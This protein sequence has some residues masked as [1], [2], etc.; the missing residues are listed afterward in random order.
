MEEDGESAPVRFRFKPRRPSKRSNVAMDRTDNSNV[1]ATRSKQRLA[2][3]LAVRPVFTIVS[4][5]GL[6]LLLVILAA[7][8]TIAAWSA[9]AAGPALDTILSGHTPSDGDLNA[10]VLGLE[11]AVLWSSSGGR[12]TDLALLRAVQAERLPVDSPHR[13]AM[14]MQ[15]EDLLLRGLSANP[16]DGYAWLRLA[17]VR[18]VRGAESGQ[19]AAALMQSLDTAPNARHLW[20]PRIEMMLRYWR[21]FSVDELLVMRSQ[22]RTIW[23]VPLYR[24]P[25]MRAADAEGQSLMVR[26]S[27][28]GDVS[29]EAEYLRLEADVD[30]R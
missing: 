13:E 1:P 18:S 6:G 25:L 14:L 17:V 12:L 22:I 2:R 28:S 5:A 16:S 21:D 4:C 23:T 9:L 7:P 8:R 19:V 3:Q 27:L 11:R 15:A 10:A 24:L 20:L 30:S 26:W 29:S